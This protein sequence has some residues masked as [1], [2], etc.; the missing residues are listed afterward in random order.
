MDKS[1]ILLSDKVITACYKITSLNNHEKNNVEKGENAGNQYFLL[2]EHYFQTSQMKSSTI[3]TF[4]LLSAITL[5]LNK[6]NPKVSSGHSF[7]K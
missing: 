4:Y 2:F 7:H 1:E 6:K 3:R 5:D